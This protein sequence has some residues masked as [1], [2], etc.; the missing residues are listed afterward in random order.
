[1][2]FHSSLLVISCSAS[3]MIYKGGE[4]ALG[5]WKAVTYQRWSVAKK[6]VVGGGGVLG[7]T[8]LWRHVVS[9]SLWHKAL[10]DLAHETLKDVFWRNA[11]GE[12]FVPG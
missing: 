5:S 1:M 10:E 4:G 6:G 3:A 8:H 2:I 7:E 11:V 12:T 9:G